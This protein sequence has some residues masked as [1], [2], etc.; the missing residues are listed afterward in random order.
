MR[1]VAAT[2]V[3]G[4]SHQTQTTVIGF[5][6]R[7]IAQDG[8]SRADLLKHAVIRGRF[9]VAIRM[10]TLGKTTVGRLNDQRA[11]PGADFQRVVV[12]I[13]FGHG[14]TVGRSKRQNSLT[15]YCV[16]FEFHSVC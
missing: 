7:L 16:K 9:D 11:R 12:G 1:L 2:A 15:A 8:I 6:L 4:H 13:G 3:I 5:A 14:G 10:V